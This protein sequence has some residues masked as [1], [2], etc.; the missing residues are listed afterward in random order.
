MYSRLFAMQLIKDRQAELL[1]EARI[2]RP[3]P[4]A[5]RPGRRGSILRSLITLLMRSS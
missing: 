1:R 2:A 5:S 4:T 3:D